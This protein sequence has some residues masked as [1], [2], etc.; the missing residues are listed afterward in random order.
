MLLP[1]KSLDD[2]KKELHKEIDELFELIKEYKST[3]DT[4]KKF[5]LSGKIMNKLSRVQLL[6]SLLSSLE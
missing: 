1:S 2:L 4:D 5:E 6:L 3:N